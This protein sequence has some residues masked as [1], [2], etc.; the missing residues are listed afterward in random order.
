MKRELY[1]NNLASKL[2]TLNIVLLIL[3]LPLLGLISRVCSLPVHGLGVDLV[4]VWG[5][6]A[7]GSL[8]KRCNMGLG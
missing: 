8:G 7:A 3:I 4:G 6:P 2:Q 1:N 5:V